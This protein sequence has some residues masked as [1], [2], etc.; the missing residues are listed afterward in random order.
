AHETELG[1]RSGGKPAESNP[2]F[3]VRMPLVDPKNPGNSYLLYKLFL[4]RDNF[5]PCPEG[6]GQ[7]VCLEPADASISSHTDLPLADGEQ[8]IPPPEE[9]VRLREWFVRGEPMPHIRYDA[10]GMLVPANV[11]LQGLRALSRF[12]ADGARCAQ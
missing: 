12:I 11:R 9:L 7:S 5:E 2:R 8:L 10:D 3:G 6:A 4:D 1:D